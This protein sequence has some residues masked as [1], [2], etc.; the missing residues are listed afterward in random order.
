MNIARWIDRWAGMEPG[1]VALEFENRRLTYADLAGRISRL[2]GLLSERLGVGRGDRV[3]HLGKNDPEILT[4]VFA[5]ARIGAIFVPLNW[6]LAPPELEYILG[7]AEPAVL[8]ADA[9]FAPIA[10]GLAM[11]PGAG[12]RVI[13]GAARPGWLD[14]EIETPAATSIGD[15]AGAGD[16]ADPLMIVY[17]SGTTG[18]PK[19]AVLTQDAIFH[20]AINGTLAFGLTS[21]DVS[22]NA[23]PMFHVGGLNIQCL[24]LLHAGGRVIIHRVFDPGRALRTIAERRVTLFIA[25]PAMLAALL[26]HPDWASADLSSLRNLCTG[27]STVPEPMVKAVL[28]RG[29]AINQVYGTTETAPTVAYT[30]PGVTGRRATS[31]GQPAMHA[32]LKV[33]DDRGRA[34]PAGQTGELWAKGPNIMREYWRD[35]AATQEALVEGW[36]RTGDLAHRDEDG[37]YY[38][39]DRLKDVIISGGEN[40]HSAELEQ[41]LS[42]CPQIAEW[43]VVAAPDPRWTE[44]PVAV[45]VRRPGASIEA[46]DILALFEG[47]LA[48]YKH[49]KRVV[50]AEA[51]PRN[52]MGKVLKYVLRDQVKESHS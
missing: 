3:A 36:F 29:L 8:F 50:F 14:H 47:R 43:A 25:V 7:N 13:W 44:V 5:C 4:L 40:I 30:L 48:R 49:P 51:L 2:A 19:G 52:A 31:C 6:R 35:S 20:T 26:A 22:L 39:D 1:R 9:E 37:F 16:R 41:V 18:R 32:A 17:T 21:A 23:L 12:R 33:V 46:A 45:I 11:A 34:L 15:E 28:A 24:P 38:I 42:E 27:A 10:E